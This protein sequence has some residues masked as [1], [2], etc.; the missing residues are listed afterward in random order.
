MKNLEEKEKGS[1]GAPGKESVR[2]REGTTKGSVR[3]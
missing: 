2:K 3:V 1:M